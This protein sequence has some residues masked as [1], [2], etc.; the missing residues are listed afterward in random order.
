MFKT[1]LC[2]SRQHTIIIF[3]SWLL[4]CMYVYI[5]TTDYYYGA[6]PGYGMSGERYNIVLFT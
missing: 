3:I 4:L 6:V 2:W 1:I 5:L